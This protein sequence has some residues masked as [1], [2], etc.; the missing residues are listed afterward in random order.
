MIRNLLSALLLLTLAC[1][2]ATNTA[3][4]DSP[5]AQA[6][7]AATPAPQSAAPAP[8]LVPGQVAAAMP[9]VKKEFH[10][11]D[12]VCRIYEVTGSRVQKQRIC[13]TRQ[14][15]IED[16]R[17]A[18]EQFRKVQDANGLGPAVP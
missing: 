2:C 10:P 6:Q 3:P 9:A 18:Q 15:W 12:M 13:K 14:Q 1:G 5:E 16:A 7:P 4:A 11:D 8:T 17:L